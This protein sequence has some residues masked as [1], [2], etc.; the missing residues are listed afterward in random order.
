MG[1][2]AS[3]NERPTHID[4]KPRA[5]LIVEDDMTLKILWQQIIRKLDVTVELEWATSEAS[6]KKAIEDKKKRGAHYD[7]VICDIFLSGNNTGIDLWRSYREEPTE[8][9][10]TSGVSAEKFRIL[11]ESENGFHLFLPK[12]LDPSLC[13][14]S[15]N[16]LLKKKSKRPNSNSDGQSLN[17]LATS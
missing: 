1:P 13:I 3:Y 2:L 15:L 9:I 4:M 8:F 11:L 17:K 12:P 5:V 16:S 14:S 7:V 6:A 10:F